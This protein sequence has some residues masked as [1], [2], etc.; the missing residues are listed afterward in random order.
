MFWGCS[1]WVRFMHMGIRTGRK[2][3]PADAHESPATTRTKNSRTLSGIQRQ[4]SVTDWKYKS[5]D[6][7]CSCEGTGNSTLT[8]NNSPNPLLL[9]RSVCAPAQGVAPL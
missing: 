5:E 7:R 2:K 4:I 8:T 1:E 6:F 3:K 9:E